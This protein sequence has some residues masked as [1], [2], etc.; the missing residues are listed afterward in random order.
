MRA[1]RVTSL[2]LALAVFFGCGLGDTGPDDGGGNGGSSF[3]S[4][5]VLNSVGKTIGR[6]ELQGDQLRSAAAPIVL[7]ENF[8]GDALAVQGT[9][10]ATTISALGGSQVVFGDL[11]TGE[12]AIVTFPGTRGDEADPSKVTLV[13]DPF[14]GPEAWVA[15][16]GTNTIYRVEAGAQTATAVATGVGNFAERVLPIGQTLV[17]IDANLDDDGGTFEPL[18]P[19]RVFIV[20]RLTGDVRFIIEMTDAVGASNAV[21][22]QGELLVLAGGS[23]GQDEGGD[24]VPEG[25]GSLVVVNVTGLEVRQT[26]PLDGNGLS[27]APGADANLYITRTSDL[28]STDVLTYSIFQD[29]WIRGPDDPIVPEDAAGAPI[30]CWVATALT[31]GRILC[32]TFS[33]TPPGRLYLLDAGGRELSSVESGSGS[34]D[35]ALLQ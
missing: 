27:L 29:R 20:D 1:R 35:I 28:A 5:F 22:N 18:G 7:P 3:G 14:R 30:P 6:F 19:P 34:T 23:F 2:L 32:A 12:Q 25:N 10:F 17:A 16:R 8:D 15:G 31:D 33:V 9:G 13:Q 24:F 21:F 4:I 26:L 11:V